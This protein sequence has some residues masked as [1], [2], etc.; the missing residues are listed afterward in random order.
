MA[1]IL[2]GLVRFVVTT[3]LIAA[4]AFN[5]WQ[6]QTL[7]AEVESLK[8]GASSP[9]TPPDRAPNGSLGLLGRAKE[10]AD[11]AQKLLSEGR[12]DL[13]RKELGFAGT[14]LRRASDG[15][16]PDPRLLGNLQRRLQD[17]SGQAQAL[18][19]ASGDDRRQKVEK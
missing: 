3:A 16:A 19:E 9:A 14:A 15:I 5:Y 10:H 1:K 13:A 11:R 6:V 8:T 7:R 4:V 18:I 12:L 17:L 2:G